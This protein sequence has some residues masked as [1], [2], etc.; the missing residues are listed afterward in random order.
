MTIGS[1]LASSAWTILASPNGIT[2]KEQV[3]SRL[4]S[5]IIDENKARVSNGKKCQL[6]NS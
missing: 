1:L 3:L 6:P 5:R 2:S 4:E